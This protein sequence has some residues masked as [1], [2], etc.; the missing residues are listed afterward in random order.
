VISVNFKPV[1][2]TSKLVNSLCGL[3]N[4]HLLLDAQCHN[5]HCWGL[6]THRQTEACTSMQSTMTLVCAATMHTY[7][8][9][10]GGQHSLR[11][12]HLLRPVQGTY[13]F[14]HSTSRAAQRSCQ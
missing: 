8:H 13:L 1:P 9:C 5:A 4:M 11:D 10:S 2:P 14:L 7:G 6:L 12:M 3:E